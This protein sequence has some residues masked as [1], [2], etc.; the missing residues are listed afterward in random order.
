MLDRA[1]SGFVPFIFDEKPELPQ[2]FGGFTWYP[3]CVFFGGITLFGVPPVFGGYE[4]TPSALAAENNQRL[5][6]RHNE[7]L[8]ML[9][10]LFLD[11][12]YRVTVTDP[13]W[14]NY[15]LKPDLRPFARYPEIHAELCLRILTLTA[16]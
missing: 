6:E 12:G 7:S 16:R 1:I 11:N 9:P 4:Y 10:E 15:S 3:N 8:L 13:T 14:S 2:A 5:M